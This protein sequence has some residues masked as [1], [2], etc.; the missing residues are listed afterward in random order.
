[1]GTKWP[2]RKCIKTNPEFANVEAIQ[3]CLHKLYP[4]YTETEFDKFYTGR[5]GRANPNKDLTKSDRDY[6]DGICGPVTVK[7]IKEFQRKHKDENGVQ[8][9]DAG[10]VGPATAW[11]L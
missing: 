7:T 8:L 5:A 11:A 2:N 3:E 10:V 6:V 4:G 9:V 1:M